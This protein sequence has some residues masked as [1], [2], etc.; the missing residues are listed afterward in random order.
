[1]K[2]IILVLSL[3]FIVSCSPSLVK[4][5]SQQ[6]TISFHID[7]TDHSDD[8][9]HVTVNTNNL[10]RLNGVYNFAATVPG[11]Y[12]VLDF[13]RFVKTFR[14]YDSGG[15]ELQ[16]NRIS[17]NQWEIDNPEQLAMLKYDIEDSFD[18]GVTEDPISPM[19]GSGIENNFI[20]L[21]TFAVLGYFEGLQSN[22][23]ELKVDY[24][25][26]WTIGTS[27]PKNSD[28][29]YYADTYDHLADSPI[30]IGNL[31]V[32]E[33]FVNDISVQVYIASSD[34]LVNADKVLSM[35]ED[36]LQSASSFIG[37]S[38]VPEYKFLM[39]LID[40]EILSRNKL[41]GTG[42]LE[43][44]YSSLYV[45]P[46]SSN[47]LN[48]L[49]STM[50]HEFLHILT[51]LFLHSEIIHAF[52]F[53]EPT[54]SKH[55]WLYEGVTEW[56]SDIMQ[57]RSGVIDID[58]YMRIISSKLR[59]NDHFDQTVSLLEMA[60]TSYDQS[61][62]G[63]FLNFYEKGAVTVALLDIRI[64]ELSGGTKGFREVFLTFLNKYGK[65]KPFSEEDIFENLVEETYPEISEFIDSYIIRS[66]PLP[67]KEYFRKLGYDYISERTLEDSRPSLGTNITMNEKMEIV[68]TGVQEIA[69][70]WGL[71]DGDVI[72]EALGKI[73]NME[74]IRD[75]VEQSRKMKIGDP[76]TLKVFR[77]NEIID[78]KCEFLQRMEKHA[79]KRVENL[80]ERQIALRDV[81]LKN[82]G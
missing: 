81:W 58:N 66:E 34:S 4:D 9:F 38:P 56:A 37:Y 5:N 44:S 23:I 25:S 19:C 51:P 79:F 59:S 13:G 62:Y 68:T 35:A 69:K 67:Y 40:D 57:L 71:K 41:Y 63:N 6:P 53:E 28:G 10:K 29:S 76:F 16:V 72:L 82:L 73:V 24:Q 64:L 11:T 30:L 78:I 26:D 60:L 14:A 2:K 49:K 61:G 7:V 17:T 70:S 3:V 15:N 12:S 32:A 8:L 47:H 33:T 80:T 45:M 46:A 21:N 77:D 52:N 43:H 75:I 20:V 50:A 36:V 65:N 18:A 74:T 54:P 31:T 55:I 48:G 42:A 39:C 27:L 1:M 22:P